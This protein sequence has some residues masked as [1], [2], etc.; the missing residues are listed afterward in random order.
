M[1]DSGASQWEP[2]YARLAKRGELKNRGERLWRMMEKCRLCPRECGANRLR[3]ERGTCQATADLEIA[4]HHLHFGEEKPLVGSGGSGTVFFSHCNLRCDFCINWEISQGGEGCR[5]SIRDLACVML[6][7]QEKGC[8]N[9]NVVTP[10]HYSPHIVQAL[11]WAAAEGLRV[12]LVYN[13]SGWERLEVLRLLDGIVDIYL[14]DFKYAD[15]KVAARYSS[16]AE[17]YPEVTRRALLEMHRQVGVARPG[18]GG[19]MERGLMIRHLVMPGG[20]SGTNDVIRWIASNLPRET[21]L[22]IMSQYMP[23]GGEHAEILR[24]VTREEFRTAVRWAREAGLR[25]LDI[26]GE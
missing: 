25:N 23:R 5:K 10:T 26:Q 4:S 2:P 7:L 15:P 21:Y 13:T 19:L 20:A 1:N 3:G 9:I 11:D 6:E 8:H 14:A 16:G 22:N 24:P 17:S 12:P 18:R